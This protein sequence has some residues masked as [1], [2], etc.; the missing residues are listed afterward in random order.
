ML[1][2]IKLLTDFFVLRD[3]RQK[4]RYSGN[5]MLLGFGYVIFLYATVLPVGLLVIKHSQYL[6]LLI[7]TIALNVLVL[8]FVLIT[9]LRWQRNKKALADAQAANT[10]ATPE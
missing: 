7:T 5:S 1:E 3:L 2:L 4:G 6:W 9:G 8:V 10:P